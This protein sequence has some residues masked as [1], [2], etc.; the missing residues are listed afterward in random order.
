MR[1]VNSKMECR[2]LQN[3]ASSLGFDLV[4]NNMAKCT[5]KVGI[6]GQYGT[7]CEASLRKVKKLR[8][9]SMPSTLAPP[10]AKPRWRDK[11]SDLALVSAWKQQLMSPAPITPLLPSQSNLRSEDFR[12]WKTRR[13]STIWNLQKGENGNFQNDS[14]AKSQF[15]KQSTPII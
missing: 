5:K 7:R 11:L 13:S 15:G 10:V 1:L 3:W 9:A 6:L 14:D 8:S 4:C 2:S 12:N